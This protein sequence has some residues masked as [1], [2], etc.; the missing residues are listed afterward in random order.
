MYIQL[1]YICVY[2]S[3]HDGNDDASC[4]HV[5]EGKVVM[6]IQNTVVGIKEEIVI[7]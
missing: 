2:A 3:M 1:F 7:P 4:S 5:V 6:A